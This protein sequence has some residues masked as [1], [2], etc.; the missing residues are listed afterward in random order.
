[1]HLRWLIP[2]VALLAVG[3]GGSNLAPVSGK[4]T[5]DDKPLANA[6]VGFQPTEGLNPGAGSFGMTDENGVYILKP[7]DGKGSG[8]VVGKHRVEI[9]YFGQ[10]QG[11][12]DDRTKMVNRLPAQ[13]N[14]QSKLTFD[15]KPGPN[16]ANF[17]L[18]SK[19]TAT[20]R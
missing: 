16:T 1:M 17:D 4:I 20:K 9:Y 10:T 8:A 15:V 5:L 13:Y 11:A 2:C 7:V 3:C 18:S 19:P 14:Q 6:R 12:D